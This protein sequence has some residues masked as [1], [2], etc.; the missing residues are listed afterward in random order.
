M[1]YKIIRRTVSDSAPLRADGT[2]FRSGKV[3]KFASKGEAVAFMI[4]HL[5]DEDGVEYVIE[6]VTRD[7]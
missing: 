5:P 6:E 4:R 3:R 1:N 2:F 7:D